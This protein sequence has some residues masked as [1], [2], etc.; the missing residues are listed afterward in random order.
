MNDIQD[1]VAAD[2]ATRVNHHQPEGVSVIV[3]ATLPQIVALGGD[4]TQVALMLAASEYPTTQLTGRVLWVGFDEISE[5][6]HE[7]VLEV[8]DPKAGEIVISRLQNN[9]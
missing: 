6:L 5:D 8:G 3:K 4:L 1:R 2:V 7:V 9:R